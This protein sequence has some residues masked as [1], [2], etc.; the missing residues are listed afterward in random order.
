MATLL[1]FEKLFLNREGGQ[2]MTSYFKYLQGALLGVRFR[3]QVIKKV[4]KGHRW[5][6]FLFILGFLY[7][8]YANVSWTCSRVSLFY[9]TPKQRT[10]E[11]SRAIAPSH[12]ICFQPINWWFFLLLLRA[13]RKICNSEGKWAPGV[14]LTWRA[15]L[16]EWGWMLVGQGKPVWLETGKAE[17]DTSQS[18]GSTSPAWRARR[19]KL[20]AAV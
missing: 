19:L 3:K 10:G 16:Y 2:T 7:L 5:I 4:Y 9:H 13:L 17:G 11:R 15:M 1:H 8:F 14:N 12:H 6:I 18:L 20:M